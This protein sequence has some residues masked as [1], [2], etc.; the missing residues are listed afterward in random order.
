MTAQNAASHLGLFCLLLGIS[1]K[2]DKITPDSL[3]NE[4]GLAQLIRMGKSIRHKWV[5][6]FVDAHAD[7]SNALSK[8][9][10]E[11]ISHEKAH[12]S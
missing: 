4:S 7:L 1:S 6:V 2:N 10:E 8:N 9:P 12:L 5:K 3:S 11:S